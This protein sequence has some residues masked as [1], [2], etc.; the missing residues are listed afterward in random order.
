ML[1]RTA[2]TISCDQRLGFYRVAEWSASA[3]RFHRVHIGWADVR[4]GTGQA[5][6]RLLR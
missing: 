3:V 2:I 4:V 5:N 6:D 1:R